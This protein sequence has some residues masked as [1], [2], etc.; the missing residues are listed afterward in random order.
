MTIEE[1]LCF[2]RAGYSAQ[3]IAGFEAAEADPAPAA[4]PAADPTPA[5][6]ADPAP[7]AEPVEETPAWAV[8]LTKFIQD[9]TKTMQANNAR[10]AD[11]G[12][13][14]SVEQQADETLAAYLRGEKSNNGGKN[15]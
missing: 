10:F 12:D 6:A 1:R 14:V 8:A 3:D 15:K 7:V 5:Q 2:I 13:P 9:M 11:M 4:D